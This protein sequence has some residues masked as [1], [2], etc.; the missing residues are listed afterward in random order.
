MLSFV[1]K[2]CHT[3]YQWGEVDIWVRG[4]VGFVGMRRLILS[5]GLVWVEVRILAQRA[6]TLS[7]RFSPFTFIAIHMLNTVCC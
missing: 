1:V 6:T 4:E 2:M 5:M 3:R 7:K